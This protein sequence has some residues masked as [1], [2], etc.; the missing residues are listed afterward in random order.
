MNTRG[1]FVLF[2]FILACST[3]NSE[4]APTNVAI[5][6]SKIALYNM[7]ARQI[8]TIEHQWNLTSHSPDLGIATAATTYAGFS[9]TIELNKINVTAAVINEK[10]FNST[11]VTSSEDAFRIE[12][13]GGV[14]AFVLQF[15]FDYTYSYITGGG[16][17]SG[18]C[19]INSVDTSISTYYQLNSTETRKSGDIF[20]KVL[21]AFNSVT[22]CRL[23]GSY[24]GNAHVTTLA[25]QAMSA[26]ISM[27]ESREKINQLFEGELDTYYRT[28][29]SDVDFL[30]KKNPVK[31]SY[32]MTDF[33]KVLPNEEGFV[34]YHSGEVREQ[35]PPVE[36]PELAANVWDK[37]EPKDGPLQVFIS[38]RTL[39]S[40]FRTVN[41]KAFNF[42][43][44]SMDVT[45]NT[46]DSFFHCKLFY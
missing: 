16:K 15:S 33:P 31:V 45:V 4:F 27:K 44:S 6:K 7:M 35:T 19:G 42:D 36:S 23:T 43:I 17:G 10:T 13:G 21:T 24:E 28:H 25:G 9:S 39:T 32:D 3:I 20:A 30:I 8:D 38:T 40:I 5:F 41:W 22:S 34:F 26:K 11:D 2:S 12:L 29:K 37:F 1:L 14:D 46:L 18:T